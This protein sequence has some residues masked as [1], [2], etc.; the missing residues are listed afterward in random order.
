MAGSGVADWAPSDG[1]SRA[2]KSQCQ[3]EAHNSHNS[4]YL[5][6]HPTTA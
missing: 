4:R 1:V 5:A 3:G 6:F 2:V